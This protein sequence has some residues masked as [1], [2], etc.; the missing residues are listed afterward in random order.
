M[1]RTV[2]QL[3]TQPKREQMGPNQAP[4]APFFLRI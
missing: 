4:S 3:Q 1:H 2:D